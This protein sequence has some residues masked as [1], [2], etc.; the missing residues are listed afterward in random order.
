MCVHNI[1]RSD[2]I[3]S[4]WGTFF[5][6]FGLVLSVA[7]TPNSSSLSTWLVNDLCTF[8][9]QYILYLA[10]ILFTPYHSICSLL[11]SI[12]MN[13]SL[14]SLEV[15]CQI[16]QV[17]LILGKMNLSSRSL[18]NQKS[19][20]NIPVSIFYRRQCINLL[21]SWADLTLLLTK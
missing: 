6:F 12:P 19:S 10:F 16:V 5:L 21:W 14:Q 2:I 1:A 7:Q 18:K 3:Y 13:L 17:S 20:A 11:T 9:D 4:R 8:L 15:A